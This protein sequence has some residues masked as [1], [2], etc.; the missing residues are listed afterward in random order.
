MTESN[1]KMYKFIKIVFISVFIIVLVL[2]SIASIRTFSLDV[3]AGLQ[4]ARWE[5]TNNMSLVIDDHQREELLAKFKEAIRIPTVSS[6]TAIN[7]TA[8]SQ[9]GE[10]LRKA[11][12]TVFSSSL[13][14]HEL[15]A[16]YS[17]L[18]YVRGSQPD[19]IPYMLLAHI[20]V[21]PATE[22]DGW[23]APPFS[24]KEIDGFIYGRGTI[25]D[26]DSLMVGDQKQLCI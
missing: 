11:F 7:I 2:L 10:L 6:D 4:L 3:N 1:F 20:D 17:H 12:P 13:V 5:K 25:D 18:F 23:E 8:L 9:F 24:A 19:L 22:S 14:Q 21:V 16:N 26:K 15:V